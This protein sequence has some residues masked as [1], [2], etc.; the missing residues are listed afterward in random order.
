[1]SEE[2]EPRWPTRRG[3][4]DRRSPRRHGWRGRRR[5]RSSHPRRRPRSRDGALPTRPRSS[6]RRRPGR[7]IDVGS[8]AIIDK[9]ALAASEEAAVE[10]DATKTGDRHGRG[11]RRRPGRCR[12]RA[13]RAPGRPGGAPRRG[14]RSNPRLPDWSGRRWRPSSAACSCWRCS[15]AAGRWGRPPSPETTRARRPSSLTR[16]PMARSRRRS[17]PGVHRGAGRR[18]R[19]RLAAVLAPGRAALFDSP[20]SCAAST[21]RRSPRSTRS[22]PHVDAGQRSATEVV[23]QGTLRP[24]EPRSRST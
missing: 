18:Q 6:P 1:M 20:R 10:R 4:R 13:D 24:R 23:M 19:G 14:A 17:R 12:L 21:S 16:A 7:D 22:G 3:R 2:G 8:E 15:S 9:D 11:H 5:A